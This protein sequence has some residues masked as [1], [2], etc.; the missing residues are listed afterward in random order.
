MANENTYC[1]KADLHRACFRSV[2]RVLSILLMVCAAV[3]LIGST[4][5]VQY[6]ARTY[7][8]I[9]FVKVRSVLSDSNC[10]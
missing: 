3:Y 6:T 4:E 7:I 9:A 10:R 8:R 5:R 2:A 1:F